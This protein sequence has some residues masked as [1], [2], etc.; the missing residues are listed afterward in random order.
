MENF[1]QGGMKMGNAARGKE[2][3]AAAVNKR[4][5]TTSSKLVKFD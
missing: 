1:R 2:S 3:Q 4:T 5:E